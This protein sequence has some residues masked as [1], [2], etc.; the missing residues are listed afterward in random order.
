MVQGEDPLPPIQAYAW[1]ERLVKDGNW[2]H[3][4]LWAELRQWEEEEE[5]VGVEH[6]LK[7]EELAGKQVELELVGVEH[8]Q[9]GEEL[10]EKQVELELAEEGEAEGEGEGV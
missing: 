5:G 2:A 7:G 3:L 4:L 9:K 8:W 10:V 1:T 6:W